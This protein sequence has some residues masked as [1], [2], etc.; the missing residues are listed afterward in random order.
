M[1]IIGFAIRKRFRQM[2]KLHL[3]LQL[4]QRVNR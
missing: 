2:S 1:A 4:A 3:A